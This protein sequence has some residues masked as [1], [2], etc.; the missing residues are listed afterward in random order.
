MA[1]FVM[2]S[3]FRGS[4][5]HRRQPGLWRAEGGRAQAGTG[6]GRGIGQVGGYEVRYD[7]IRPV[8]ASLFKVPPQIPGRKSGVSSN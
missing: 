1:A 7:I 8:Q 5:E 2:P 3:G 6:E 4:D